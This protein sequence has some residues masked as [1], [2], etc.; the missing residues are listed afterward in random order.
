MD[1]QVKE[2]PTLIRE[3]NLEEKVKRIIPNLEY[4]NNFTVEFVEVI[5]STECFTLARCYYNE[6]KIEII[7]SRIPEKLKKKVLAHEICHILD[8]MIYNHVGHGPSWGTLML[9]M[10]FDCNMRE[11]IR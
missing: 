5:E 2:L 11:V 10:G 4:L 6:R 8:K 3:W 1:L 9:R 7:N